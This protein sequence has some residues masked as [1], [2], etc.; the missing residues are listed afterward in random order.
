MA[1]WGENGVGE[2]SCALTISELKLMGQYFGLDEFGT[3]VKWACQP[4]L[5]TGLKGE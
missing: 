2:K 4:K 5:P 3:S 1:K